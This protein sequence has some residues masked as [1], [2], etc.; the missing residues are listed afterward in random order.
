VRGA[1]EPHRGPARGAAEPAAGSDGASKLRGIRRGL[2]RDLGDPAGG[3]HQEPAVTTSRATVLAWQIAVGLAAPAAGQ[4]LVAAG[5]LD[6]FFV[7]RPSLILARIGS[8]V[9]T[10]TL[11]P[12]LGTTLE[13]SL[14]GLVVGAILGISMGFALARLPLVA[15]V[16][17]PYIKM[18]NAVPRV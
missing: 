18:L 8:W 14:L 6:P 4:G 17:D 11:W 5:R 3:S 13:E 1:G 9:T 7:S 15:A 12:H 16:C 10:G 2:S